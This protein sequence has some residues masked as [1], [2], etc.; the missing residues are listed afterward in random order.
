MSPDVTDEELAEQTNRMLEQF[1]T[2]EEVER[3]ATEGD[4]VSV[5]IEAH[6]D[7]EAIEET[8]ASDLLYEVGSGLF[9]EGLDE[10][11]SGV[12]A[13]AVIEFEAPLPPGFGDLA[14]DEVTFKISVNEVKERILPDLTDEWVDEN[15]EFDTVD[16]LVSELRERLGDSK[17]QAVS[18]QYAERALTTLVD[19]VEIDLPEPLIRAEMDNHLHSFVHRLE[20]SDLTLDDYFQTTGLDQEDFLGDLRQQAERSLS[21]Q[22]VLEAVATEEG[23]DVTPEDISS[24]VQAYAAQSGDPVAYLRAFQESGQELALAGDILRNR[25][26]DAILSNANPVDEDGYPVDLS[27]K[28]SEVE[29]EVVE[30]EVLEEEE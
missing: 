5:D 19:Q 30:A 12:S 17:L 29:A 2:V 24:V 20:D 22:L 15:T 27:L 14:G 8:L 23:I 1:G 7:G 13:G 4:F 6:K 25:A 21:N 18:R 28:V 11:V 9:I 26:L 10:H 3:E 16:E